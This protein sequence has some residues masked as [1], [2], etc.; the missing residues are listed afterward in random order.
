MIQPSPTTQDSGIGRLFAGAATAATILTVAAFMGLHSLNFFTWIFPTDQSMYAYLGFGL[1]GGAFIGYILKFKYQARTDLTR[2]IAISMIVITG[3]GELAA[4]GFGM[5]VE[6]YKNAGITFTA[7]SIADMIWAVRILGG[8]HAIALV[9][10]FIGDDVGKAWKGRGVPI[11][12]TVFDRRTEAH[13][14]P[15]ESPAIPLL[16]PQDEPTSAPS[17]FLKSNPE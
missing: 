11:E 2:F 6:A 9:L 1:T 10:E 15:A 14:F 3:L 13:R 8:L 12:N 5:Q 7:E 17:P 16:T 4:A